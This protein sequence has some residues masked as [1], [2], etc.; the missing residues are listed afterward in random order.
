MNPCRAVVIAS[1]RPAMISFLISSYPGPAAQDPLPLFGAERGPVTLRGE[2]FVG[3]AAHRR[4]G[5]RSDRR[6]GASGDD[7]VGDGTRLVLEWTLSR[8]NRPAGRRPA[9][10]LLNHVR[11]LVREQREAA[12]TVRVV[13]AFAKE[14]VGSDGE[15]AGTERAAPSISIA[16]TVQTDVAEIAGELAFEERPH[17]WTDRLASGRQHRS[18]DA[19]HY[20]S[21]S[22]PVDERLDLRHAA[23]RTRAAARTLSCRNPHSASCPCRYR[24]GRRG[25]DPVHAATTTMAV[26]GRTRADGTNAQGHRL[27][28]PRSD[29]RMEGSPSSVA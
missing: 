12:V 17:Q 20:A 4:C 28:S 7:R 27:T 11:Q 19:G 22:G 29:A 5:A 15:G 13:G 2:L 14:N 6:Q 26:R 16:I 21:R 1:I 25:R 24:F 23:A 10:A 18:L 9:S 3:D 8:G